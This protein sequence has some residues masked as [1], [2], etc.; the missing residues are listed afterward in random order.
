LEY[1]APDIYPEGIKL[2]R[3]LTLAGDQS[4]Y[5]AETALTPQGVA[6]PQSYALENSVT[7]KMF[8]EPENF[9][10]WFAQD[11]LS[12]EFVPGQ[13]V[14]LPDTA[15]FVGAIDKRTG[16]TLA[17]LSLSPLAKSQI[18]AQP[19]AATIRMIYP[20]FRAKNMLCSYRA[21]Y[22]FGKASREEIQDL[23]TRLKSGEE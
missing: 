1:F 14:D 17:L 2:E 6:A 4:Y 3:T 22:F 21:A 9:R 10:Q 13:K 20:H 19:H 8:N 16:E 23:Y 12:E 7:F 11:H 5:L 18:V 15:G